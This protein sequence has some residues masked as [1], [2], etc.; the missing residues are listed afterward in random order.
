MLQGSGICGDHAKAKRMQ[1]AEVEDKF[2]RVPFGE[3]DQVNWDSA[4][5]ARLLCVHNI[6]VII[7]KIHVAAMLD[8]ELIEVVLGPTKDLKY[9]R[10]KLFNCC[11]VRDLKV[12]IPI[13]MYEF[14]ISRIAASVLYAKFEDV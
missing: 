12:T 4:G 9:Y 7:A 8:S 14:G 2:K 3:I 1:F 11:F 5:N 6:I 10:C 13:R